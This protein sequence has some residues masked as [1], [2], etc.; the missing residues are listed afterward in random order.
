ME[1]IECS[2][3]SAY[4]IQTP[5]NYPK[6]TIIYSEHGESL[7]SRT[8]HESYV[9]K[10]GCPE[11]SLSIVTSLRDWRKWVSIYFKRRYMSVV[12]SIEPGSVAHINP[13][14]VD[15]GDKDPQRE[16]DSSDPY[17]P[18]VRN[19]CTCIVTSTL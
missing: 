13:D 3:T 7:K 12:H 16:A 15:T 6:E 5:G 8:R 9:Y 14:P 1:Q 4:K 18:K 2:E 11:G 17:V 10:F 19:T